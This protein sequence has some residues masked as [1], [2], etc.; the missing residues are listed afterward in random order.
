M[1]TNRFWEALFDA[2][3]AEMLSYNQ[4]RANL[5]AT[6]QQRKLT[7]KRIIFNDPATIVIWEDGSKTVVKAHGADKYNPLTGVA[8]CYMK[9]ALGNT[10][11]KLNDT[12]KDAE[13]YCK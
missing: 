10:S 1:P 8:L 2:A 13:R 9:K 12:L 3:N 6:K 5:D 11:R 7:A 4:C